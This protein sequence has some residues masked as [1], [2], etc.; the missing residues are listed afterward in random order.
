MKLSGHRASFTRCVIMLAVLFASCTSMPEEGPQSFES[1][2]LFG[3]I[4]DQENQPVAGVAFAIDRQDGLSSD[5]T[6]RFV[7]PNL[8][9]GE[10]L[11]VARKADFEPLTT[12]VLFSNQTQVVYIRMISRAELVQAAEEAVAARRIADAQ[13][14][15]DR[16]RK[17]S[18]DDPEAAFLQ[19]ILFYRSRRLEDAAAAL[20][21]LLATGV[22]E[23][24]VYLFLADLYEQ[25]LGKPVRALRLLEDGLARNPDS[26]LKMRVDRL[27]GVN[28]GIRLDRSRP[29]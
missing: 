7:I 20:E 5:V 19:A 14:L 28:D 22:R 9:R 15:I 6:G 17:I 25:Q 27:C 21:R 3:M 4:Y 23:V 13:A 8:A 24:P 1:A 10:H 18:P 12:T 11:L 2:P 16:I 26:R 29:R